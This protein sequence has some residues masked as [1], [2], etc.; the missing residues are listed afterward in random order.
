MTSC[1][2]TPAGRLARGLAGALAG[3]LAATLVLGAC[4]G[5]DGIDGEVRSSTSGKDHALAG[6]WVAVLDED[7]ARAWWGLTGMDPP[8][9]AELAY[10]D[11]PVRHG[12]VAQAGGA[13]VQVDEDGQFR[14]EVSGVRIVC[15][16][17]ALAQVDRIGGCARVDLP[18]DGTLRLTATKD[19]LRAKVDRG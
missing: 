1:R 4:G 3:F 14:L 18:T 10:L 13:L 16:V 7:S 15:R 19:G 8:S 12:D 9:A 11:N 17:V 2:T 6:D 5:P